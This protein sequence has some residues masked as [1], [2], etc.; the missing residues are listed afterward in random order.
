[1]SGNVED[2]KQKLREEVIKHLSSEIASEVQYIASL[3]SRLMFTVLTGPFIVVGS[4]LVALRGPLVFTE[5]HTKL[6]RWGIAGA[7]ASYLGLAAYGAL[8]DNH[9]TQLC[10]KWRR[11]I[12]SLLQGKD[13]DEDTLKVKNHV[14]WGYMGGFALMIAAFVSLVILIM[15]LV[16]TPHGE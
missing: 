3:R 11:G 10:N 12:A 16:P 15:Q 9:H 1:M 2:D 5:S 7:F 8:L 14:W 4:V 6:I 13:P